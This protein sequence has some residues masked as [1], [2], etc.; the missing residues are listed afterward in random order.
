MAF[1]LVPHPGDRGEPDVK[2]G[3]VGGSAVGE[4]RRLVADGVQVLAWGSLA[5]P[6]CELPISPAPRVRP[7]AE[8]QCAFCDHAAPAIEFL[9]EEIVDTPANDAKLVARIS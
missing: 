7:R 1:E 5:C 9:R 6:A 4:G 8:L 3:R 2:L